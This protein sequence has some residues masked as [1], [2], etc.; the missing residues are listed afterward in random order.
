LV[1]VPEL[2]GRVMGA[3]TMA[4]PGFNPVTALAIGALADAAGARAAFAGAG[5]M[6]LAVVV[7]GRRGLVGRVPA[8]HDAVPRNV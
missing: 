2:R 1:A 4:L 5:L 3:W 6:M 8:A 7:L